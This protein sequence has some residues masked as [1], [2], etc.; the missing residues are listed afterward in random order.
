[1]RSH[2]NVVTPDQFAAF[3]KKNGAQSGPPGLAVF[4]QNGCGGC[5]TYKPAGAT[6]TV[7]PSLD[8]LAADAAKAKHGSLAAYV[9]E[10]I[11]D[12]GSYIVPGYSDA[13]PHIFKSQIPSNQLQQLVQYL[14]QGSK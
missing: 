9:E 12:P 1:M 8:N 13:M 14:S 4:Q 2:A 5:H 7:G 11:V 3:L 6:G 10:S